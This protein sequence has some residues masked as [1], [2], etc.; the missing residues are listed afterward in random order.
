LAASRA[1][2]EESKLPKHAIPHDAFIFVGDGPKALFLH[3][4]G[5]EK[6]AKF[7]TERVLLDEKNP[8]TH[9]QGTDKPGRGF[10]RANTSRRSA[11]EPTDWHDIE[12]HRFAQKVAAA[13]DQL[14]RESAVRAPV[15]VA[16]PRTLVDLRKVLDPTVGKR[17]L[18][19]INKDLTKL[20]VWEIE[21]QI[22][23]SADEV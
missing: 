22:T 14:V 16:P 9:D 10:A 7:V 8:R 15:I 3:N 21:R 19:E 13:L 4:E 20:P 6:F 17:V 23:S 1:L 5:D 18:L 11:M 12:K 2:E